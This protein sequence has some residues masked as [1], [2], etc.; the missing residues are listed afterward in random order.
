MVAASCMACKT[1]GSSVSYVSHWS[2][3][4]LALKSPIRKTSPS[5]EYSIM[6]SDKHVYGDGLSSPSLSLVVVANLEPDGAK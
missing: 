3:R 4:V 6:S 2:L 5:V 1:V